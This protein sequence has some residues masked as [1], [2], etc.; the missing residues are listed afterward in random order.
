MA[1]TTKKKE[2]EQTTPVV[3]R[4]AKKDAAKNLIRELL[5]V[6][7]YKHNELI[8]AASNLYVERFGEGG[9]NM[10]DVKGRIGSVLD[11]M[12]KESD[13]AY[14]GGMYALNDDLANAIAQK[15]HAELYFT[16]EVEGS[17]SYYGFSPD[18]QEKILLYGMPINLHIVLSSKQIAVGSPIIFGGF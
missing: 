7:P 6:K 11:I 17:V 4:A 3:T 12:K 5:A 16:E 15:Y 2:N 9:E 14:E 18:W 10:N 1:R 13:V 8:D